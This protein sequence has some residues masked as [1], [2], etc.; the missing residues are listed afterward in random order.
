MTNKTKV[1]ISE[2][3]VLTI[4]RIKAL[5]ALK[6][7][8][9]RKARNPR[10]ARASR[11]VRTTES[12]SEP[13]ISEAMVVAKR[14]KAVSIADRATIT[15]SNMFLGGRLQKTKSTGHGGLYLHW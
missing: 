8:T 4:E 10:R 7:R 5:N 6:C 12:A 15:K 13:N 11:R 14:S 9:S 1:H 3:I 2:L